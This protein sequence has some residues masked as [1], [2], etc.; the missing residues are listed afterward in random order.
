MLFSLAARLDQDSM[1]GD[2]GQLSLLPE[3]MQEL[4][5]LSYTILSDGIHL[6]SEE[7]VHQIFSKLHFFEITWKLF[8]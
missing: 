3:L 4:S 7:K 1:K 8:E 2:K 6:S 5:Y